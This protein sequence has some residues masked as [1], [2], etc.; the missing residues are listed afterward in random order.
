MSNKLYVGGLSSEV[1]EDTLANAFGAY[2]QV[3]HTAVVRD[4]IS[5]RS[6]GHGSVAFADRRDARDAIRA[7]HGTSLEGKVIEVCDA[8]EQGTLMGMRPRW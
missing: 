2:G 8:D 6:K 3:I 4:S 1:T 5:G 7:M